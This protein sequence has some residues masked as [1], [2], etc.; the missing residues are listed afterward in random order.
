MCVARSRRLWD[1]IVCAKDVEGAAVARCAGLR[2][3]NIVEGRVLLA[4]AREANAENHC[5]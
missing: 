3:H 1:G 4:E 2:E 5:E